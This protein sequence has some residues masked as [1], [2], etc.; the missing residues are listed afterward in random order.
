MKRL[1]LILII[2]FAGINCQAQEEIIPEWPIP[3]SVK[4]HLDTC[5][6]T[7]I[8]LVGDSIVPWNPELIKEPYEVVISLG[9]LQDYK[10]YCL[11]KRTPTFNG[12]IDWLEKQYNEEKRKLHERQAHK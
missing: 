9:L 12:F 5:Q 6:V 7:Y 10:K 4:L 1:L 8:Q 3:D 2:V 11:N